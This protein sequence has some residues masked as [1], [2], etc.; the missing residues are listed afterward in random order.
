V[1][2]EHAGEPL[3]RG[4]LVLV[5]PAAVVGHRLAAEVA[6][7]GLE[8][9]IVD[10]DDA[11]LAAQVHPLEIVPVPLRRADAV[12]EEDDGGAVDGDAVEVLHRGA[13]GDLL[14]LRQRLPPPADGE[15]ELRPADDVGLVERDLLVPASIGPAGLEPRGAELVGDVGDGLRLTRRGRPASEEVVGGEHADVRRETRGVDRGRRRGRR[16]ALWK[17]CRAR[18]EGEEGDGAESGSHDGSFEVID[19][20]RIPTNNKLRGWFGAYR[21]G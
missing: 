14:A 8:V 18:C 7:A 16:G 20:A 12:A 10:E 17:R 21:R 1:H 6:L 19:V 4:L 2:D 9:G 5:R 11:D 15:R 3:T 13:D